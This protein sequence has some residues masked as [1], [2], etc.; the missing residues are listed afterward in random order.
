VLF[1][2]SF[3]GVL[4][5]YGR[6]PDRAHI[7][8]VR[9]QRLRRLQQLPHTDVAV[10]SGRPLS[11]LRARLDLGTGAYYIGLHG[12][13]IQGPECVS[14]CGDA[15]RPFCGYMEGLAD[16]V[17]DAVGH[18]AGVRLECKGPVIALH[19]RDAAP[20]DVVWSR[21]QLL[22][23]AAELVNAGLV[24]ALRGHDVLELLPSVAGGSRADA[25]RT[26]RG[27]VEARH[28]GSVFIAY[29]AGDLAD[30]ESVRV[31]QEHGVAAVVG[32]RTHAP[33]HIEPHDIDALLDEFIALGSRR[34]HCVH[35]Q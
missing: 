26:V 31:I 27:C 35:P 4:V 21:F 12:L 13:E 25:L 30:D 11:D 20:D 32:R 6:D 29:C 34:P 15:V 16:R 33:Y 23:A 17:R 19:T 5:E 9:L 3:D 2:A 10:I 22:G 7:T 18:V 28:G 8:P 24:R 14:S 1:V